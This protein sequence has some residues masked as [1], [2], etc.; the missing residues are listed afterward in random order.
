MRPGRARNCLNFRYVQNSKVRLPLM[1]P[2]QRIVIGADILRQTCTAY[3]L[4]EHSTECQAI[5]NSAL[6]PESDDSPCVLVHD[7][8]HP[9]RLQC[10]RFTTEEVEAPKAIL[11]M[12]DER[13]PRGTAFRRRRRILCGENPP[14]S[15]DV[16]PKETL[17]LTKIDL[18]PFSRKIFSPA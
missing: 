3:R 15:R 8:Q 6:D 7:D 4:L 5:D 18:S 9:I 12:A 10:D 1:K 11:H 13:Q 16:L 14:K 2:V 17:V